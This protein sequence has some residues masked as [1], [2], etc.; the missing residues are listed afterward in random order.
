[1][2][3]QFYCAVSESVSLVEKGDF[4][5]L[6]RRVAP[7]IASDLMFDWIYE[8]QGIAP[9]EL[10]SVFAPTGLDTIMPAP[11]I[12]KR[13]AFVVTQVRESKRG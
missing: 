3:N 11:W 6:Q 8:V 4:Q 9:D 13:P 10:S 2:L 5:L 12:R 7:S 1:M